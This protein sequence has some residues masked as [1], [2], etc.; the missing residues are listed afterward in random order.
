MIP[1]TLVMAYYE[2]A[3]MLHEQMGQWLNLPTE[4]LSNLNVVI[5][6]DG[7]TKNPAERVCKESMRLRY[8]L[9]DLLSSFQLWRIKV[10][11]PWNQDAARNIGVRHANSD[12]LLITDMDHLVPVATWKRLMGK[13]RD[14]DKAYRFARVSMP[15][16]E[17]YKQHPNSWAM[18][19]QT[20]WKAGGYDEALAGNYG[21]DGDFMVRLRR[22]AEVL[23][24]K[25]ILVRYPREVIADASTT[26]YVRKK[27]EDK[28]RIQAL[29]RV[30]AAI[31]DW[32]PKLFSF[33]YE[34][35]L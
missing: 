21:T 17:P 19:R 10:D 18:T 20:Y 30:R 22:V 27:P 1:Y 4:I 34:R 8:G 5:V 6:D 12:W 14:A 31:P 3:E 26:N 2:N 16:M 28:D 25:E 33:P 23:D 29:I 24:L 7:S 32:K 13:V 11:I 35:V 15:E 9:K